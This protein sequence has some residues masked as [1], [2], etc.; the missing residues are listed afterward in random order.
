M[1]RVDDLVHLWRQLRSPFP[2]PFATSKSHVCEWEKIEVDV[3]GCTLCGKV[4]ACE[5]GLC[6]H[7]IETSDALVCELS[8]VVVYEK[9]YVETEFMDTMCIT[10]TDIADPQEDITDDVEQIVRSL[11]C[12]PRQA[13][14]QRSLMLGM[15]EKCS[16]L[17]DKQLRQSH[18]AMN[19]CIHTLSH[20]SSTPY[21]FAYVSTEVRERLVLHTVEQCVRILHMLTQHG[22]HIR[23]N[24]VQRLAVG[25]VYLMRCGV[26]MNGVFVLPRV[27]ELETLL[28]PETSLLSAFGI[29][30][31]YI[32]EME[33]RLK[34][35][36]RNASC[37]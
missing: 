32:T 25:I 29:H 24:E 27:P 22:M 18:N 26:I 6:Q 17:F 30:P 3:L 15:L 7:V 20:F 12:S 28:P 35:C 31:K 5:Y 11:L 10:G 4:H 8:G 36:L 1:R 13:R 19:V 21:V 34:Y 14:V 33:N 23:V 16:C 37:K 2:L 9:R